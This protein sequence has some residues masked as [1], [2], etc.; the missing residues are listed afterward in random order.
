MRKSFLSPEKMQGNPPYAD[1]HRTEGCRTE[2]FGDM[3]Q[4]TSENLRSTTSSPSLIRSLKTNCEN[5]KVSQLHIKS[6]IKTTTASARMFRGRFLTRRFLPQEEASKTFRNRSKA[7]EAET[8]PGND[9][10]LDSSFEESQTPGPSAGDRASTSSVRSWWRTPS[11]S[12]EP[13][14]GA[15]DPPG[16][17]EEIDP[18]RLMAQLEV[19]PHHPCPR[20]PR[21][22]GP[23]PILRDAS[24]LSIP[25]V[26]SRTFSSFR[27]AARR[28]WR[29]PARQRPRGR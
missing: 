29:P 17:P 2:G 28:N 7:E 12:A 4:V 26:S 14:E 18:A 19:C 16:T 20:D 10:E 25:L 3:N 27:P 15:N 13:P 1:L 5:E 11:A 21:Y 6:D 24:H 22:P 8:K 9:A 23:P